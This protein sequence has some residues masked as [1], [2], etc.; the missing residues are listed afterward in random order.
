MLGFPAA[1]Q[2]QSL[3]WELPY[4]TGAAKEEKRK[5]KMPGNV[6]NLEPNHNI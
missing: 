6:I 1:A 4:T 3:A 5:K 2:I